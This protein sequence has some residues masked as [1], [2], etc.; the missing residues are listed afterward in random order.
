MFTINTRTRY[1]SKKLDA[2]EDMKHS[3]TEIL[4]AFKMG[5]SNDSSGRGR[6]QPVKD[7]STNQIFRG[8]LS[9]PT[10]K[11]K[12]KTTNGTHHELMDH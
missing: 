4:A 3:Y 1:Q 5:H 6:S 10:D 12:L 9:T 11:V 7:V 8:L 2:H